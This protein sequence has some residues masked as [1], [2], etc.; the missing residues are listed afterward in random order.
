MRCNEV[1]RKAGSLP[2]QLLPHHADRC[3]CLCADREVAGVDVSCCL[4]NLLLQIML[5]PVVTPCGKTF[6]YEAVRHWITQNG[7]GGY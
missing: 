1:S 5:Q 4:G 3:Q 2:Q 6:E 7:T